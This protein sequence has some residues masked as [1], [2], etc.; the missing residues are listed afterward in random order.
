MVKETKSAPK[1]PPTET[2]PPVKEFRVSLSEFLHSKSSREVEMKRAFTIG[3][4]SLPIRGK[5]SPSVWESIYEQF[6]RMP[7][8]TKIQDWIK[9]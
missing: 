2:Q 9:L 4:R 6:K 1:A 7:C 8:G 5:L 3:V